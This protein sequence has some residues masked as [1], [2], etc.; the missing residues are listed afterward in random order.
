MVVKRNEMKT[1]IKEKMRGGE[2]T[3]TLVHF[4]D[5]KD[6]KNIRLLAEIT[7]P[8]GASIGNHQHD[9]ETE[10]FLVVSGSGIVDDSGVEKPVSAGDSIITGGGASHSVKNTGNVPLVLHAAIVTY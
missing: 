10:Y 5:C 6:E 4:T 3:V 7:L 1:E 2:G 9:A 8:P